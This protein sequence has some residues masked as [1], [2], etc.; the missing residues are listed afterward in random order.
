M[1]HASGHMIR[2]VC[3]MLPHV[4]AELR[5]ALHGGKTLEIQFRGEDLARW[6]KFGRRKIVRLTADHDR[7]NVDPSLMPMDFE[8]GFV[9]S[10]VEL[11]GKRLDFAGVYGEAQMGGGLDPA[12]SSTPMAA[13]G[14]GPRRNTPRCYTWMNIST[15]WRIGGSL[16]PDHRSIRAT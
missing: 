1:A 9:R 13:Q 2:F 16:R 14:H 12:A 4:G 15:E 11:A 10:L 3:G 5:D 7:A 8:A 6:P